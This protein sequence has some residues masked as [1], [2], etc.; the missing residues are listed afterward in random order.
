MYYASAVCLWKRLKFAKTF[1][2]KTDQLDPFFNSKNASATKAA[3]N[4]NK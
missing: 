2:G 4:K 3:T 1:L